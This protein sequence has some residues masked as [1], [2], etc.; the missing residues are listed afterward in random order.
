M[1]KMMCPTSLIFL[2]GCSKTHANEKLQTLTQPFEINI[3]K[4]LPAE[5]FLPL[6]LAKV[7]LDSAAIYNWWHTEETEQFW[8]D[9]IHC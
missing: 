8:E 7:A 5:T 9:Q 1:F 3:I 2:A 4:Y 6:Y